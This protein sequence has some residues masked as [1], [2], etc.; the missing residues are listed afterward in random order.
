MTL[1]PTEA[2]Q[3]K[4]NISADEYFE[5][6]K[7]TV[8]VFHAKYALKKGNKIETP[9]ECWWRVASYIASAEVDDGLSEQQA[10]DVATKWFWMM[11]KKE[12]IPGGRIIYGANN[13]DRPSLINCTTVGLGNCPESP[14]SFGDSIEGIYTAAQQM[15]KVL[16]K[17]EG[18]GIDVTG[19]RPEHA[20]VSNAAKTTSGAVSWMDLY[21]F[22]TGTVAQN[23]RRGALLISIQISHPETLKFIKVKSDLNKINNANISLQ[24]TDDFMQAVINDEDWTFTWNSEEKDIYISEKVKARLIM[25][26]IASHSS[27]YAEPGLQFL[28]TAR[29]YS[30]SDALGHKV[31]S[32][33]ACCVP[34]SEWILTDKGA[35]Q[36]KDLI[37]VPF[38]AIVNGKS[39]KSLNGFFQSG[40]DNTDIYQVNLNGGRKFKATKNHR[41]EVL[42]PKTK[43]KS[44][45]ELKDIKLG[46]YITIHNH[47]GLNFDG[48]GSN[49][50]GY[51]LGSLM[52][53][54]Y[55]TDRSKTLPNHSKTAKLEF[56]G[57][58]A[59][60][61]VAELVKS[62]LLETVPG[63]SNR[64]GFSA[65]FN[66]QVKTTFQSTK[67][68]E[69]AESYG[70][71]IGKMYSPLIENGVSSEFIKGF[72]AGW[73]DADGTV[74]TRKNTR[75]VRISN[76]DLE[77]IE[78]LQ[79]MLSRIGINS[80]I[81]KNRRPKGTTHHLL[82]DGKG[83]HKKYPVKQ[84]HEI[85]IT[86]DNLFKFRDLIGFK[87]FDKK[88]KLDKV[89]SKYTNVHNDNYTHYVESIELNSKDKVYDVTVED[90]HLFDLNG[91]VS[92]N[93]EQFLTHLDSCVL[94]H[95]NWANLSLD[96]EEAEKEAEHRAYYISWFLDNVVTKQLVDKLS[97][98]EGSAKK[99]ALLRRI[100][101]GFTGLGD[102]FSK[103][104]LAYDSLEAKEIAERLTRAMTRGAYKRSMEAGESKGSFLAFDSEKIKNSQ[105]IKNMVVENVLPSH[106]KHLR[107]VCNTTVAPV[108]T[109]N[110]MV[111]GW[112]N[113]V[114]PGIGYIYW[115]RTRAVSGTYQ[116]YFFINPFVFQLIKDE[117]LISDL[118]N[119]E[120]EINET[121]IG[122][123]R[124]ALED[125]AF[126]L[127]EGKIDLSIHKFS[128]LVN[129]FAKAKL[130]GGIQ[131][132]IDSALSVTFN[133]PETT[134]VEDIEKLYI[135]CWKEGLKGVAIYREDPQNREPIFIF[136]RPTS[137]NYSVENIKN[138]M[139]SE[140]I[141]TEFEFENIDSIIKTQPRQVSH[142][143]NKLNGF[144]ERILAENHKFYIT[145]NLDDNKNLYELFCMSNAREPKISTENAQNV[146]CETLNKFNVPNLFIE[147]Q[148]EKS[149]HQSSAVKITR[150]ISLGL[151]HG[152][153]VKE[154]VGAL[155]SL[156]VTVASYLYHLRR[157]LAQFCPKE[158]K[159]CLDCGANALVIESGCAH[160]D[161]CGSSKC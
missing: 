152:V 111:N 157:G 25:Q 141:I 47:T 116:W 8:D 104:N 30:N 34:A 109:G 27:I 156:N 48:R 65:T 123:K 74:L 93:S 146:I 29:K 78:C 85:S 24:I 37:G 18:V 66:N 9:A 102:Y 79:R 126:K 80:R 142:R 6:Q 49:S 125:K 87:D 16:S 143:P 52:G 131:K 63:R 17:G 32:T 15:A 13:P 23:G 67:L 148:L 91:V 11:W 56:W 112:A 1:L 151:R 7:M 45:K 88:N 103:M 83:G 100:G 155:E 61:P 108:G 90:I 53:D 68:Y 137:Y 107:N 158:I 101:Q 36:V 113:G 134:T 106:I 105:F 115:R 71:E 118:K 54:G 73:F 55:M 33:N 46:D 117:K 86:K 2:I 92:H 145:Y 96:I 59:A 5:N 62:M 82:P 64:T 43:F 57:D 14:A 4:F 76:T 128:H 132:Y 70:I 44:F 84:N 28:D 72:I 19:L 150:L 58:G 135:E 31:I 153:P 138:Q 160:C 40:A 50:E 39:Y 35:K 114:E 75:G 99:S 159:V 144:T 26:E 161:N 3:A 69:L 22:T 139:E 154:L 10:L 38:N 147:D 124:F 21:D 121:A 95:S 122:K 129:P 127:L 94:G 41:F 81:Y 110:L 97:P 51:L 140:P 130:M 136:S 149:A 20:P 89:L 60:N 133:M 12:F 77:W 119:L 98:L 120:T 42:D